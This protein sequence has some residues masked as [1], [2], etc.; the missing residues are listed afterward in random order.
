M[1]RPGFT[2][3]EVLLALV[4][5]TM[6]TFN[7]SKIQIR[8]LFRIVDDRNEIIQADKEK[9]VKKKVTFDDTKLTVNIEQ[10]PVDEKSSLAFL[11]NQLAVIE[12]QGV[13]DGRSGKNSTRL[14]S[15]VYS[16]REEKRA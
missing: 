1:I 11:N 10:R 7:L 16:P 12:A 6:T 3:V 2:F 4:I 8:A 5:L 9:E 14:A 13:W 15:F